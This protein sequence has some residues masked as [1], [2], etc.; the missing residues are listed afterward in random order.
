MLNVLNY[1]KRFRNSKWTLLNDPA[2][3]TT[4]G[5]KV[6]I[7]HAGNI[8]VVGNNKDA[9]GSIVGT[10]TVYRKTNNVWAK[11]Q[12]LI[13]SDGYS[14]SELLSVAISGDGNYI[15]MG[16]PYNNAVLGIN[17]MV[18]IFKYT[19][20]TWTEQQKI[21]IFADGDGLE[22]HMAGFSVALNYSGDTVA[23]GAYGWDTGTGGANDNR[24]AVIIYTR[25]GT[26]WTQQ[27]VI[28][29]AGGRNSNSQAGWSVAL[30]FSGNTLAI[31]A[32]RQTVSGVT[33]AG[34]VYICT[35]SGTTWS[36]QA[37]LTLASPY[38]NE[39]FGWSVALNDSGDYLISGAPLYYN[40]STGYGRAVIFTR[41]GT[42][43]TL[44]DTKYSNLNY[45][46]DYGYSVS[47]DS[48][49]LFY[50]VG[51]PKVGIDTGRELG[52]VYIYSV[53]GLL[54]TLSV[55]PVTSTNH[56]FGRSIA[57][58]K[59]NKTLLVGAP[60]SSVSGSNSGSYVFDRR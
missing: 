29:P 48:S 57:L 14:T 17:A 9:I 19:S 41:S 25:S 42:T 52:R 49:G 43:W 56:S 47:I 28:D 35:R 55:S 4:Q 45:A 5:L 7:S 33:L 24:G 34:A 13:P 32:P 18:F 26:T 1:A 23:I 53:N 39:Q 50:V 31:G 10:A 27:A 38:N 2:V 12:K 54:N 21:R 60:T 6:R 40:A 20:G 51:A 8:S 46:A 30:D 36:T 37:Q 44:N 11:E 58:S 15:A 3:T 22:N 16:Y 59:T